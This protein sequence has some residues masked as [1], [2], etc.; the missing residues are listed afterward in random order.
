M[1]VNITQ[2][3]ALAGV[4]RR[5]MHNHLNDEKMG[6]TTTI[7]TDG[8]KKIDVA[9]LQRVY[10]YEK[11]QQ[12]LKALQ[13]EKN[14]ENKGEQKSHDPIENSVKY[15]MLIAEERLASAQKIIEN[16]ERE[17]EQLLEDKED[18]KNQLQQAL[19]IGAPIGKLL[20][21]Q[22]DQS[23]MMI[24]LERNSVAE[25]VRREN[26][27]KRTAE[28]EEKLKATEQN[29]QEMVQRLNHRNK[30]LLR[31]CKELETEVSKSWFRKFVG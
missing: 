1:Q 16:L 13:D 25:S 11:V 20:T 26:A 29:N 19:S 21:D 5:T 18:M 23:T 7:D 28:L 2:A 6:I 24:E 8:N 4:S 3:A 22:R 31:K 27:E 14:D 30:K 12:N 9:E 10:G 17:R 15:E